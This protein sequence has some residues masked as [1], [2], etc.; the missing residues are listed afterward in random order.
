MAPQAKINLPWHNGAVKSTPFR[1]GIALFNR[2]RFFDAH[3]VLEDVWRPARGRRRRF[4]QALIQVAVGLHHHSCG[5]LVGARSL[6]ARAGNTL[7]SYPASYGGVRLAPLRASLD[8]WRAALAE[9][10][11]APPLP[12]LELA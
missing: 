9:G 7:A 12:K 5:N 11:P 3:E 8:A 2:A 4:L 10:R 6:L 1:R